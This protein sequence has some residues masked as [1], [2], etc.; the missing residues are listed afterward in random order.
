MWEG[1]PHP[2]LRIME[3][4]DNRLVQ[5]SFAFSKD[6]VR[7]AQQLHTKKEFVL[8]EQLLKSGTSIGA[9]ICEAQYA[10]SKADFVNKLQIS[11]KEAAETNYW[12]ALL[13]ETDYINEHE[14][15]ALGGTCK[16]LIALLTASINT[17]KKA[18]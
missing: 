10:Q 9:N 14:F 3:N 1:H 5:L 13:F 17:T 15:E 4:K 2:I 6:I 8:S 11:L 16:Q 7:T 18:L 12:I